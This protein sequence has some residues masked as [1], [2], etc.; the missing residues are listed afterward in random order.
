MNRVVHFEFS[1]PDPTV[2]SEFFQEVFG[3]SINKWGEGAEDYWLVSTGPKEEL[4]IDGGLMRHHDGQPRTV[5]TI[6]VANV[7]DTL[8]K[9]VEKGGQVALPKMPIKGVG[10]LA[11]CLDPRGVLFGIMHA[12]LSAA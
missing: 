7:D 4:G 3:W 11:Y 10:Y 9:V 6:Q 5:N 12:D 1:S 2:S 8:A